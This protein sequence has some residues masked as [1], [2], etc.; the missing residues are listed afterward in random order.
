MTK[1]C[2]RRNKKKKKSSV[3]KQRRNTSVTTGFWVGGLVWS[4][5]FWPNP[6]WYAV[7]HVHWAGTVGFQTCCVILRPAKGAVRS[8]PERDPLLLRPNF[9]EFSPFFEV[10]SRLPPWVHLTE[11]PWTMV[12]F[13]FSDSA[14]CYIL[15]LTHLLLDFLERNKEPTI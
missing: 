5:L 11:N 6:R 1:F 9:F 8:A 3:H 15:I 4:P 14:A 10:I 7:I 13:F 12:E 2:S